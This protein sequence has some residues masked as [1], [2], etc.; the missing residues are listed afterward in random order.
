[1]ESAKQPCCI[2]GA[3]GVGKTYLAHEFARSFYKIVLYLNFETDPSLNKR[4]SGKNDMQIQKEVYEYNETYE[5]VTFQGLPFREKSVLMQQDSTVLQ[6][7]EQEDVILIVDEIEYCENI[8]RLLLAFWNQG[9]YLPILLL[10]SWKKTTLSNVLNYELFP[11]DFEEFLEA[12]GNEWYIGVINEHF[13]SNKALPYIVHKELIALYE[14]YIF[15]GGMPDM[16]SEYLAF[17]RIGNVVE[18]QKDRLHLM[19]SDMIQRY[20]ESDAFKEKQ[21]INCLH[22]QLLRENKKFQFRVIRRGAT[23]LMYKEAIHHL[24]EQQ[25]VIPSTKLT[26]NS[27]FKLYVFDIGILSYLFRANQISMQG[28]KNGSMRKAL[29]EN[30]IAQMFFSKGYELKFWESE[31]TAKTEFVLGNKHLLPIEVRTTLHTR[32]KNL[33]VMKE[34]F[35]FDYAVKISPRN[36][37]YS[38]KVKYVPYYATFCI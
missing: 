19:H 8:Q 5:K 22:T 18:R 28:E 35:P 14:N 3:R 32:S 10:S 4:L 1:M 31:S 17:G 29:L 36:F 27:Q 33:S 15:V 11:M 30:S 7:S 24:I 38:N 6:Q 9:M 26:N 37:E 21:I 25:Y 12:T 20:G 13:D 23:Y 2:T 16:V 34:Q